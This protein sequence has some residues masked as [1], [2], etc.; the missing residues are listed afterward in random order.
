MRGQPEN[1]GGA[2]LKM[3]PF[4][5]SALMFSAGPGSAVGSV[6]DSRARSPGLETVQPHTFISPSANLRRAV[7]SYWGKYAHKVLVNHLGGLSLP[8]KSVVRLIDHS[9]MTLAVY[10]GCKPTQQQQQCVGKSQ[11]SAGLLP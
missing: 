3:Y 5:V 4:T 1:G 10:R 9:D 7:V 11:I 6:S 2:S 8:R